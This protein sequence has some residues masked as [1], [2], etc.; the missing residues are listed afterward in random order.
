MDH[1]DKTKQDLYR[2]REKRVM[3]TVALGV[4]DRVPVTSHFSFFSAR[5]CGITI[6]EMMYEP[7][8][9]W[10]AQL[11]TTLD[12]QPDMAQ[13]VF[14]GRLVGAFLDILDFKQMQWAGRQ[15]GADVPYQFVEGEYMKAEEYDHFLS[16]MSDFVMRKYWPRISGSLKGL[17]KLPPFRNI[18]SYSRAMPAFAAF[19]LPE[20]QE[21][22]DTLKKAGEESIRVASYAHR[23]NEKLKEEGF[24]LQGGG[25]ASTPF[26][27]LGDFF[28]GT[29]GL[30]LDMY[31]RPEMVIKA[32]EK[33]LPMIVE[34]AINS[35]KRSGNPRIF[36]PLHKG[37]DGFMS[38]DQFNRFY[39]PT[40][41]ELLVALINEGLNPWVFWEGDATSRLEI[42]KD[43]PAGKAVYSFEA[44]DIMKAKDILGDRICIRGNVPISVLATGT[45][46]DVRACCKKLIDYV[47]RDGG[48]IMD[49]S[50][51]LDDAKT[52]NVRAMFDFT[53]EYGVY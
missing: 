1:L 27:V 9:A 34:A 33:L 37:L 13:D 40:L 15:L 41:R 29:K 10:D 18:F 43:I 46:D 2:E 45:P 11:K 16:D 21:A 14:G 31:R 17:E 44:T 6:K 32:C 39:W 24:P 3:D 28:R 38:P 8:K 48:Y 12:F 36:I 51:G 26:D 22:L 23:F 4:P 20:V 47:G 42:I 52:E 49:S 19:S 5:Y 25:G 30:M 50:A 53:R 7:D 35:A